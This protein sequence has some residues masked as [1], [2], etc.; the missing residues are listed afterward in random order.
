M[1]Y[2]CDSKSHGASLEGS[3]P[4]SSTILRHKKLCWRVT[5]PAHCHGRDLKTGAMPEASEVGSRKFAKQIIC[6]QASS[7]TKFGTLS[8]NRNSKGRES[9][10]RRIQGFIWDLEELH[11]LSLN[12]DSAMASLKKSIARYHWRRRQ[13]ARV[14]Q[15]VRRILR[16]SQ[17]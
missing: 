11:A 8:K 17:T 13:I 15:L 2:T 4:S 1:V 12:G 9:M 10:Q 5:V 7:S 6:D 16:Q 3:S 14:R